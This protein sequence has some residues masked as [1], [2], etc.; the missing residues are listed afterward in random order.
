MN[1][2]DFMAGQMQQN[3]GESPHTRD[4]KGDYSS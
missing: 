3:F 1:N 4:K 2:V